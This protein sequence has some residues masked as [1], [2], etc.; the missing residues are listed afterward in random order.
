MELEIV[1]LIE[2]NELREVFDRQEA[3]TDKG[4]A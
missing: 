3:R 2:D 4:I 1:P